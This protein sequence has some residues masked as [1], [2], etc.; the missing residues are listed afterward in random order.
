LKAPAKRAFA[1]F[2]SLPETGGGRLSRRNRTPA[3]VVHQEMS[4]SSFIWPQND[5]CGALSQQ[6]AFRDMS[7]VQASRMV[8]ISHADL[9]MNQERIGMAFDAISSD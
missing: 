4:I 5:S 9:S 7:L 8:D 6:F 3:Y 2:H 1:F